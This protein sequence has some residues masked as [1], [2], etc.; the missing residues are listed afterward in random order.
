[1]EIPVT[2][3]KLPGVMGL[4]VNFR[5]LVVQKKRAF[6]NIIK[7]VQATLWLFRFKYV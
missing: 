3:T 6:E 1:M 4:S 5:V 7:L 2:E